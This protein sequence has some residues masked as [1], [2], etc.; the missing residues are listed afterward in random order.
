MF[1]SY[2]RD[3]TD[4]TTHTGGP[5]FVTGL[6]FWVSGLVFWFYEWAPWA[7]VGLTIG[8]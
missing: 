8:P 5:D 6:V 4:R 3:E 1:M 7:R 2:C